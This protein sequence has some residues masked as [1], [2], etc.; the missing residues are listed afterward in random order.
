M[1]ESEEHGVSTPREPSALMREAMGKAW[2][3]TPAIYDKV[4][5]S[6]AVERLVVPPAAACEML[7]IGMTTLFL[8]MK[9]GQLKSVKINKAR[10]VCVA[11]IKALAANGTAV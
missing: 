11:S 6:A 7:G 9:S 4:P 5:P 1:D 2:R 3:R 10:R 8:L